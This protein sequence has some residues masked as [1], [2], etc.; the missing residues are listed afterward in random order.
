MVPHWSR[1]NTQPK[2]TEN[3]EMKEDWQGYSADFD[4]MTDEEIDEEVLCE[5]S[6]LDEAESWLEAVAAW[7][8]AGK[9]RS[10]GKGKK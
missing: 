6:K 9:P 8:A 2:E 5:Q 7:K 3:E 1:N 4:A 10:S